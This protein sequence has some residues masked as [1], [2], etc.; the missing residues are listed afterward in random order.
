MRSEE[1]WYALLCNAFILWAIILLYCLQMGFDILDNAIKKLFSRFDTGPCHVWRDK[2][3][4]LVYHFIET[5]GGIDGLF[6]QDIK[7]GIDLS[8]VKFIGEICFIDDA[9][10][11]EIEQDGSL[12]EIGEV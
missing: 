3:T 11:A 7:T 5:V 10:S 9:A 2:Q 4:L 1:C 8:A 12:F 6:L